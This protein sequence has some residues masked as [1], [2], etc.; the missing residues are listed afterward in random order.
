MSSVLVLAVYLAA[1]AAP[2]L[3]LYFH[4]SWTWY[5]HMMAVIAAFALGFVPTPAGWKTP[6]L[7]VAFGFAFIFLMVW[8][9]GG[10]LM[11]HHPRGFHKRA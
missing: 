7:D 6:A 10:L 4:R 9:I 1:L 2:L 5:W 11:F 3:I 8:G